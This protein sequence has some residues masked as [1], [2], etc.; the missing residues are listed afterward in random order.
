MAKPD[1]LDWCVDNPSPGDVIEEPTSDKKEAGWADQESP[2][3][4]HFNWLFNTQDAWNKRL[5]KRTDHI[6]VTVGNS[7][8]CDYQT[9]A[10]LMADGSLGSD[11]TVLI[12]D[13]MYLSAD[14]VISGS[15][16]KFIFGQGGAI[17]NSTP[18]N[19]TSIIL[20]DEE[21]E[22][23]GGYF[24][25]WNWDSTDTVFTLTANAKLCGFF[26]CRFG[27]NT[28]VEVN[29]TATPAGFPPVI[30]GTRSF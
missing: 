27:F 24:S 16:W 5:D 4:E 28:G 26:G 30:V 3:A 11:I 7:S 22:F 25:A 23:H 19:T 6:T 29:D 20:D 1:H 13:A 18:G 17:Y 8:Q 14:M 9:L 21:I 15:R 2:Y 12:L 10:A